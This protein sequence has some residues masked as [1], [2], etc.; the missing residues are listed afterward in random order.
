MGHIAQPSK[1]NSSAAAIPQV[2]GPSRVS[3]DAAAVRIFP[4]PRCSVS[5]FGCCFALLSPLDLPPEVASVIN[6]PPRWM[7]F[8]LSAIMLALLLER[9]IISYPTATLGYWP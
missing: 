9:F 6:P 8:V 5:G 3:V 1:D 4:H 2:R 7:W